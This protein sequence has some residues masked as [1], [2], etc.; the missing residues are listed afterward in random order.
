MRKTCDSCMF[1]L[2]KM[3]CSKTEISLYFKYIDYVG[4]IPIKLAKQL[5]EIQRKFTITSIVKQQTK[6]VPSLHCFPTCH[7]LKV[8]SVDLILNNNFL[9]IQKYKSNLVNHYLFSVKP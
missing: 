4:L 7:A 5:S 8:T 6:K 1:V 9:D 3:K 2:L